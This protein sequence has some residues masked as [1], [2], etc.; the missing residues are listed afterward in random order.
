MERIEN[1]DFGAF[2]TQGTVDVDVTTLIC[3]ASFLAADFRLTTGAG[4]PVAAVS[5]CRYVCYRACSAACF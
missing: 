3:I 2:R 5:F 4:S 1:L